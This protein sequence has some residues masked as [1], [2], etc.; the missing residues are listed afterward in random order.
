MKAIDLYKFIT[1]NKIEWHYYDN[2]NE[3]DVIIFPNF[4]EAEEF[5]KLLSNGSFDDGGIDCKMMQ[6]YLA[7]KMREVC[8]Y[9]GIEIKDVF[10]DMPKY[11]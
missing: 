1:N 7:I 6:G 9:Y 5:N 11:S 8:E 3:P 10:E 2:S 4:S